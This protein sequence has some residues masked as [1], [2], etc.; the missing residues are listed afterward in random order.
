MY[1]HRTRPAYSP[2]VLNKLYK[3]PHDHTRWPDHEHRVS[4]TIAFAKEM[5]PRKSDMW[6]PV[7]QVV[8]LVCGDATIARALSDDPIL[9]DFAPGYDLQGPIDETLLYLPG[10]FDSLGRLFVLTE[11]LEHLDHPI[12]VLSMMS[13]QGTYLLLSTPVHEFPEVDENEE[14]YWTWDVGGVEFL[15]DAAGWMPVYYREVFSGEGYR[16]GLWWCE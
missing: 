11:T 16:Y 14:H 5:M 13:N 3:E 10:T 12:S 1:I 7:N 9:G 2:E 6:P 4:E 8:D 15:L